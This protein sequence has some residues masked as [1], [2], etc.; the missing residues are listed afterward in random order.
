MAVRTGGPGPSGVSFLVVPLKGQRGVTC[1]KLDIGGSVTAGTTYIELDDVKV[2]VENL[3]G[4]EGHGF[5]YILA[6]F[7]HERIGV[8][9]Q[10]A[11]Q[12]RVALATTFRYT[13]KREAFGKTLMEQP[14][15]RLRLAEAA[16]EVEALTAWLE[17]LVY[18]FK[19][20]SKAEADLRLGGITALVKAKA[21]KVLDKCARTGTLLHGGNGFTRTGQGELVESKP[22]HGWSF[23]LSC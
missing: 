5:K 9:V 7:N 16:A 14:V 4:K 6:N 21:G 20:L 11:R 13:M 23:H 1:K 15:V 10:V 2:P 12:A 8:S 17:Q 22:M 18:Q 19:H 3:L